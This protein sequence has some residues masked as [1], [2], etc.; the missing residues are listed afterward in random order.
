MISDRRMYQDT[1]LIQKIFIKLN[2][3]CILSFV[4]GPCLNLRKKIKN[5]QQGECFISLSSLAEFA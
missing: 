3:N 1:G 5:E 2:I 4:S